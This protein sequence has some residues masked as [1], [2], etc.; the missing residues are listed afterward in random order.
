MIRAVDEALVSLKKV[1][2]GRVAIARMR[3]QRQ[4]TIAMSGPEDR[5]QVVGRAALHGTG[6][7]AYAQHPAAIGQVEVADIIAVVDRFLT[8]QQRTIVSMS[9]GETQ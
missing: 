2:P 9:S 4:R 5:A 7:T 1:T 3:L 6:V 8:A